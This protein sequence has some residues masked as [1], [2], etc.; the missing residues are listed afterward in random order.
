MIKAKSYERSLLSPTQ[1]NFQATLPEDLAEQTE[2]LV[3]R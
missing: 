1:N 2:E 3:N